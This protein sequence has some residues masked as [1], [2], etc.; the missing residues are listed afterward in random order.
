MF[1]KFWFETAVGTVGGELLKAGA[2]LQ[3]PAN[4]D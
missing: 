1:I 3:V 2:C 4:T